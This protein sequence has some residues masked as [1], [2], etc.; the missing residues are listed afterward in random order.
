M[1]NDLFY[2]VENAAFVSV[3]R[4]DRFN[5]KTNLIPDDFFESSP[6]VGR[7]DENEI[8]DDKF[9]NFPKFAIAPTTSVE[10]TSHHQQQQQQSAEKLP[11]QQKQH[12]P[13]APSQQQHQN[14]NQNQTKGR[15]MEK[16]ER[17]WHDCKQMSIPWDFAKP[18]WNAEPKWPSSP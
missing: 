11:Q 10:K 4:R 7:L 3:S 8:D 16:T 18:E 6:L 2:F 1:T 17:G 15:Q 12:R 13:F 14:H 5:W 9:F